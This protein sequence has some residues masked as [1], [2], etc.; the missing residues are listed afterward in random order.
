VYHADDRRREVSHS[1][2]AGFVRSEEAGM[3][4]YVVVLESRV[5][6]D[7]RGPAHA[8]VGL[9]QHTFPVCLL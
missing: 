6:D 2:C 9:R 8:A 3:I 5:D 4:L 7:E 1:S